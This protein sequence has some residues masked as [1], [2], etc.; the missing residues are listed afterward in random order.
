MR[1]GFGE[2]H[3]SGDCCILYNQKAEVTSGILGSYRAFGSA[4][5]CQPGEVVPSTRY[6]GETSYRLG[7][8]LAKTEDQTGAQSVNG[9]ARGRHSCADPGY[10][11]IS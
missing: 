11:L 3:S 10:A 8:R 2:D 5:L 6:T 7:L 1:C 4:T 9:R